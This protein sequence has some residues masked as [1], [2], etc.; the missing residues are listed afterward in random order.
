MENELFEKEVFKLIEELASLKKTVELSF[1][2]FNRTIN[3][4]SSL[5]QDTCKENEKNQEML[6]E[7]KNT[8]LKMKQEQDDLKK[9]EKDLEDKI[10]RIEK[11]IKLFVRKIDWKR[12]SKW[13]L[14][15]ASVAGFI[16]E[17]I[18]K[19]DNIKKIF[20]KFF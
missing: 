16:V 5:V 13:F 8:I 17:M 2:S 9:L 3:E 12:I 7:L 10:T 15:L 18:N 14:I 20:N 11:R 6:F 4:F 1:Q 19:F